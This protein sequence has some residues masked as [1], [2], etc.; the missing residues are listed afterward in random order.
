MLLPID[1]VEAG[2]LLLG[3]FLVHR[4]SLER[5]LPAMD[6]HVI[7]RDVSELILSAF[8]SWDLALSSD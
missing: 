7:S 4:L 1:G 6:Q 5:M 2:E 8:L 3:R